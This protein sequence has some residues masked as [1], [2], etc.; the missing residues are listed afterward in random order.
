MHYILK[1][2]EKSINKRKKF[3]S[4][5]GSRVECSALGFIFCAICSLFNFFAALF[6]FVEASR[7]R[8][9]FYAISVFH[10]CRSGCSQCFY[11]IALLL[12][13][14]LL[15]CS[16]YYTHTKVGCVFSFYFSLI[17]SVFPFFIRLAYIIWIQSK[18]KSKKL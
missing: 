16:V 10:H 13:I 12:T 4:E 18:W 17:F 8:Y 11:W 15:L 1:R 2:K 6:L 14:S 7:S 5:Q 3:G 9:Y